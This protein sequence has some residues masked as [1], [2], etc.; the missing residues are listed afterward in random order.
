[1]NFLKALGQI[2]KVAAPIVT[3]VVA[4]PEAGAV[5][6]SA[7]AAA[8]GVKAAGKRGGNGTIEDVRLFKVTSPVAAIAGAGIASA[9]FGPAAAEQIC[10]VLHEVCTSPTLAQAVIPAI[11]AI[12]GYGVGD[13]IGSVMPAPKATT[14]NKA[15]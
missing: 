13:N 10:T 14:N 15:P 8:W 1:M 3:G 5:V 7:S 9:A 2:A 12:F 11:I 6:A 4:G